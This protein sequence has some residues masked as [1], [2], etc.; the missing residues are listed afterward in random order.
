MN[1][2]AVHSLPEVALGQLFPF[3]LV[4]DAE[5][6]IVSYG[7]AAPKLFGET[8]PGRCLSDL[9]ET[10]HPSQTITFECMSASLDQKWLC[11]V[12]G[13]RIHTRGQ[14]FFM[15]EGRLAYLLTPWF[16]RVADLEPLAITEQDFAPHE[17]ALEYLYL[18]HSR[19]LQLEEL[20]ALNLRLQASLTESQRLAEVEQQLN[21]SLAVAADLRLHLSENTILDAALN[22]K[23]LGPLEQQLAPGTPLTGA[24]AWLTDLLAEAR[25]EP[26]GLLNSTLTVNVGDSP[27]TLD[28]RVR[29]Y[30][31]GRSI[32]V[33]RD[34]TQERQEHLLL[35]STLEHA[36]EAVIMVNDRKEIVFANHSAERMFGY[37]KNDF[38]GAH[39]EQLLGAGI[40]SN[41]DPDASEVQTARHWLR[42]LEPGSGWREV[43]LVGKQGQRMLCSVSVSSVLRGQEKFT[44]AFLQDVTKERQIQSEIQHQADHDSL[45]GLPNRLKFLRELRGLLEKPEEELAVALIDLDNFKTIND[46]L[47]HVAGDEFLQVIAHRIEQ[48]IRRYDIACRLGGDE[49][50]IILRQVEDAGIAEQALADTL[51]AMS[52][53]MVINA[54][55]IAPTASIGVVMAT[56]GG[57][58]SD[59]LRNADLAMYE[60]K[61]CGKSRISIFTSRMRSDAVHRIEIQRD[62]QRG[63]RGGEIQAYYQPVIDLTTQQPVSF[64]ALA[65]WIIRG[66]RTVPPDEFIPIAEQSDLIIDIGREVLRQALEMSRQLRQTEPAA[67][68]LRANVNLSPRHFLDPSLVTDLERMLTRAEVEPECLTLELT[69]NILLGDSTIVRNRFAEL[70]SL[71]VRIALDDFGTGYSSL[72]YLEKYQ[73][74][75][76]KID[77]S[78]IRGISSRKVRQQLARTIVAVG[79]VIGIDVVAEGVETDADA[80]LLHRMRCRYAQGFLYSKPVCAAHFR[81]YLAGAAALPQAS[82]G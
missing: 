3:H 51:Q 50:A 13:S 69:E 80:A 15:H 12:R 54:V 65:R 67:R 31:Q 5:L 40:A 61:A 35:R 62:L 29:L 41:E 36:L 19:D 18:A 75:L 68:H 72:S 56:Q 1:T 34:L 66:G 2:E 71:G 78:F 10:T 42:D 9:L 43:E 57:S 11:R 81:Q 23:K 37:L 33:G 63:I 25:A 21:R 77:K 79:D 24:P 82:E 7:P 73:F 32:L 52:E 58:A 30:E 64:E 26:S 48:S 60:A 53:E 20:Q 22:R 4:F 47:G 38:L 76:L 70:R 74:D 44:T 28:V 55:S 59:L 17:S 49:F 8:L 39:A 46:L 16:E 6:R 14:L 45:T 27:H